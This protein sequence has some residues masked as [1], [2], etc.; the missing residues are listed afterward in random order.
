MA[1]WYAKGVPGAKVWAPNS[2]VVGSHT[3]QCL[4][5]HTVCGPLC[6]WWADDVGLVQC[7][8][9]DFGKSLFEVWARDIIQ[10][11]IPYVG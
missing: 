8:W 1:P 6:C 3:Y 2:G 9:M 4:M 10:D 5:I 7:T 11:L